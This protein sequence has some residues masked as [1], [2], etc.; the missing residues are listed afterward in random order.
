MNYSEKV[1]NYEDIVN[2]DV[3][4][5]SKNEIKN[6]INEINI[7][8][9]IIDRLINLGIFNLDN[10]VTMIVMKFI[11]MIPR[12]KSIKQGDN[13]NSGFDFRNNLMII[14]AKTV[15]IVRINVYNA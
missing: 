8:V 11:E 12:I 4:Q 9:N 13:S 1:L 14:K 5:V 2:Y 3:N 7:F 10:F 15:K 6:K